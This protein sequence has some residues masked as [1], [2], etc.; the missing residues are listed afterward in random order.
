MRY[1]KHPTTHSKLISFNK[2]NPNGFLWD[3]LA[4]RCLG[5]GFSTTCRHWAY[6]AFSGVTTQIPPS[7]R[8]MVQLGNSNTLW[9]SVSGFGVKVKRHRHKEKSCLE[10]IVP[11]W[12][13]LR[14]QPLSRMISSFRETIEFQGNSRWRNIKMSRSWHLWHRGWLSILETS[15]KFT[16]FRAWDVTQMFWNQGFGQS[17]KMWPV[18]RHFKHMK[19]HSFWTFGCKFDAMDLIRSLSYRLGYNT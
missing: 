8:H 19:C 16:S 3:T 1:K 7:R 11:T 12:P 6:F 4:R 17:L 10:T 2:C 15:P 13:M 18:R 14:R 9:D 5:V